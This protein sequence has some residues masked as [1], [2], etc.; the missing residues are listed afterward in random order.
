MKTPSSHSTLE[1]AYNFLQQ[2][3]ATESERLCQEIV[4]T[5]GHNSAANHVL[6]L[7]QRA[8]GKYKLAEQVLAS[9]LK[10]DANNLSVLNSYGLVL[11]EQ[12]KLAEASQVF[13]KAIQLN[14]G[15]AIA[16]ANLG[17]IQVRQNGEEDAEQNYR[18]ALSHD[19]GLIDAYI[20][21][22][23]LLR[24]QGRLSEL[25]QQYGTP[26][27]DQIKDPGLLL[28]R[29]LVAYDA[30]S[31]ERAEAL[32]RRGTK[33]YPSSAALW[34]NLAL[35]LSKQE[36]RKEARLAY[37]KAIEH[38]SKNVEIRINFADLLKYDDTLAARKHLA[39]ALQIEPTNVNALDILGFTWFL[40]GELQTAAEFYSRAL[41]ID[42]AFKRASFHQSGVYFV[43]GRL[44]EA[45]PLYAKRYSPS[46]E[47]QSPVDDNIPLWTE[48][49]E[50]DAGTLVW[51]DQG[52]GDELLQLSLVAD[53]YRS[54][55]DF[56][57]VT[58]ERI[59]PL[60]QRSFSELECYSREELEQGTR[61]TPQEFKLQT[62]AILLAGKL[63]QSFEDF[64]PWPSYLQAD[65][66]QTSYLR[67]KYRSLGKNRPLIGLSWKSTHSESGPHK[68]VSL[69]QLSPILEDANYMFLVLQY[70]EFEQELDTLSRSIRERFIVDSSIDPLKDMDG[71]A[72]QVGALDAVLTT[73][74]TTAHMSGSLGVPSWTLVPKV[75]PG[76]LWYWFADHPESLWYPKMRLL[77]QSQDKTWT[78]AISQAGAEIQKHLGQKVSVTTN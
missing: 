5:Q 74:N 30:E 22:G 55:T 41:E 39:V 32:F 2:G 49:D 64:P 58:S 56:T 28:V 40:D 44:S 23:L 26:N 63:R 61:K 57:L 6:A 53:A 51:T 76:W 16:Y 7:A 3:N 27:E 37:E 36:R 14:S 19:P 18:K 75:G 43:D 60:V 29:G 71:F 25:D 15:Y 33:I 17:H 4:T 68:S 20:Q 66:E 12:G 42:P 73:S 38:E 34:S 10:L 46:E 21:L 59:K 65:P 70:G 1:L 78:A 52:V 11:M 72:S 8:Q 13:R 50:I 62:P 48:R 54:S 24:K 69:D 67:R 47:L 35:S 31:F 9:T 77:R 45:W